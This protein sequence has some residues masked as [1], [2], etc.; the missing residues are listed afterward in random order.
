MR[1]DADRQKVFQRRA[2]LLAGGKALLLSVLAGRMYYLQVIEAPR[3]AMLADENRINLRLLPPPRG[4]I[5]DRHGRPLAVNEQTY[6]VTIV[7]E[8]AR[9]I[10]TVLDTLGALV[11]ISAVDRERILREVRRK[12][13]F[14]PVTVL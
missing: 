1:R 8:Q 5:L 7:A 2:V 3:Y 13:S 9:N 14:V 10:E 4:R 6:R 11:E 12:R